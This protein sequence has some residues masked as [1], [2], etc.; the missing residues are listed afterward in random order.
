MLNNLLGI[1]SKVCAMSSP[2]T[3][4]RENLRRLSAPVGTTI[5]L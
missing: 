1:D 5:K 2:S 4:P 3:E